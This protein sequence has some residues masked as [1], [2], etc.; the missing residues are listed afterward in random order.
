M[1]KDMLRNVS[2][3]YTDFVNI[4]NG[5]MEF[6]KSIRDAIIE[7]IRV[8]PGSNTDD[9]TLVLWECLG[10]DVNNPVSIVD[11]GVAVNGALVNG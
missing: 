4:T 7:Q 6:D 10:I 2:G 5:W 11:D 1:Y 8:N 9:V 3:S